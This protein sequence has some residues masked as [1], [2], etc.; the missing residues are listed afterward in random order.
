MRFIVSIITTGLICYGG[1]WFWQNNPD[2]Q[3]FVSDF[4]SKQVSQKQ[5]QALELRYHADQIMREAKSNLIRD[6]KD[7]Y[8]EPELKFY[9]YVLLDIKFSKDQEKTKEAAMLW[10]LVDGELVINTKNWEVTHGYEDCINTRVTKAEFILLNAIASQKG[11]VEKRALYSLVGGD[12]R[13]I[14]NTINSCKKKK[15]LVEHTN[16][17]RLHFEKPKLAKY[18]ITNFD[19]PVVTKSY[20]NATTIASNYTINQIKNLAESAFGK[21]FSIRNAKEVFLPI[22]TIRI[23]NLDDTIQT[24]YWNAVNGVQMN[25]KDSEVETLSSNPLNSLFNN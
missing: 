4:L 15:L 12:P 2:V 21:D 17:L 23:E 18:P 19:Q 11:L 8:Q 1:Y 6:R 5:L 20:K 24:T 25:I 9:P 22:Y 7:H 13:A 14:E 16:G 10:S 3:H